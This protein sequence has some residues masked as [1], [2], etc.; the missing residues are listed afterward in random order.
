MDKKEEN[1]TTS[2]IDTIE[3]I[4]DSRE[5]SVEKELILENI[6]FKKEQ[7]VVGD[8]LFRNKQ[9]PN[10]PI[11]ICERK[12]TSDMFSSIRSGR[13]REQ[14]ERLKNAR[15]TYPEVCLIYILE[16][17]EKSR[18]VVSNDEIKIVSGAI[19]NLIL[20]HNIYVLPTLSVN[21]TAKVLLHIKEKISL[22]PVSSMSK[23]QVVSVLQ[24]KK[25]KVMENI[26]KH[27]LLLVPG[28][29]LAVVNE[30]VAIYPNVIDLV[31]KYNSTS[32]IKEKK[33]L[34]ANIQIGKKKLGKVVSERIYT[35]YN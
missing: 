4:L 12:T 30:I 2:E 6:E 25:T 20:F 27:Q 18:Y 7:L 14:R 26:F 21:H 11:V 28:V 16:N 33:Y 3:I 9:N 29:S 17:Y 5:T 23:S 34:L 22:N 8:V 1:V 10:V 31:T 24:Q 19:E 15:E 13:Y 35:V 32:E